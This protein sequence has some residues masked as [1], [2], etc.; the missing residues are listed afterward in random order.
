M[1]SRSELTEAALLLKRM[2]INP[3]CKQPIEPSLTYRQALTK[4]IEILE[5]ALGHDNTFGYLL[6]QAHQLEQQKIAETLSE[7]L[8]GKRT[9]Q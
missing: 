4:H 7:I 8:K 6:S 1:R 5:W 9:P 3:N 2:A